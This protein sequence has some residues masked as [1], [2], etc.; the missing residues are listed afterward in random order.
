LKIL[1]HEMEIYWVKMG[2]SILKA[3]KTLEDVLMPF[4]FLKSLGVFKSTKLFHFGRNW[5]FKYCDRDIE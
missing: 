5:Y 2:F 4:K 1:K 3:K